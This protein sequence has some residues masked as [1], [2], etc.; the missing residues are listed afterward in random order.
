MCGF[1]LSAF[2]CDALNSLCF[3]HTSPGYMGNLCT[4]FWNYAVDVGS[5]RAKK[6]PE[7]DFSTTGVIDDGLTLVTL[8]SI[9]VLLSKLGRVELWLF[10]VINNRTCV[11]LFVAQLLLMGETKNCSPGER[12]QMMLVW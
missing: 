11:T 7:L 9:K 1:V 4:C 5:D 3:L 10:P 2:N 8:V 6:N 12:V